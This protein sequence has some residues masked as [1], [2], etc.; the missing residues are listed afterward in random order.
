VKSG[1]VVNPKLKALNSQACIVTPKNF[2]INL[3]LPLVV[4]SM[5]TSLDS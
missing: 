1:I 2:E 3:R 5:S 4:V